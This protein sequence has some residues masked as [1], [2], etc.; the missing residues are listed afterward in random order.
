MAVRG[1]RKRK[2]RPRKRSRATPAPPTARSDVLARV[3][4]RITRH[5]LRQLIRAAGMYKCTISLTIHRSAN[6]HSHFANLATAAIDDWQEAVLWPGLVAELAARG[7]D[8]E[9]A[10]ERIES[11]IL[12]FTATESLPRQRELREKRKIVGQNVEKYRL[13]MLWSQEYLAEETGLH[14]RH[15]QQIESGRFTS[16]YKT[17]SKLADALRV[18]ISQLD[19]SFQEPPSERRPVTYAQSYLGPPY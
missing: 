8:A 9:A 12:E 5:R 1:H 7:S 2:N 10:L 19:E 13:A 16:T 11:L 14:V 15:I 18:N 6:Q 17:I 3:N 4:L